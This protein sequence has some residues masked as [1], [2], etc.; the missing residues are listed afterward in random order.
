MTLFARLLRGA[1]LL[2][3]VCAVAACATAP[4][5]TVSEDGIF[6]PYEAQNRKVHA[7]NRGLDRAI[8]RPAAIG[9][10]TILPDDIEDS[11]GNF[12]RNLGEPSVI[13]NSVLQGDLQGAGQSSVRF[14][15]NST[16]GILGLF[17]VANEF[18]LAPRDT[19]FGETLYVW[20]V[21]EGAYIELPVLGPSTARNTTGK[22]VDLF[23]NPLSY[24]LDSP[25]AYYGTVAGVASGLSTRGRFTDT[26]DSILYESADSYA[27]ARLIYLQNRR[28]A[29]GDGAATTEIDPFGLDTEGF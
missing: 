6:D 21:G 22:V 3:S 29:L 19:D 14:V 23:T 9:Y 13:V 5:D 2:L 26:V 11:V 24:T 16:L 15:T 8:V 28:F 20:G 10:S 1:L 25:E 7:F 4:Q 18:D 27:Q 12:A 17:D